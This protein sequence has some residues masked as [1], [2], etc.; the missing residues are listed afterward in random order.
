ML[1]EQLIDGIREVVDALNEAQIEMVL[2]GRPD[3]QNVARFV[4]ANSRWS[5]RSAN[6]DSVA[7]QVLAVFDLEKLDSP[8]FWGTLMR[9]ESGKG[10]ADAAR[11][12]YTS[13]YHLRRFAPPIVSLLDRSNVEQVRGSSEGLLTLYVIEDTG[14]STPTRLIYALQSVESLYSAIAQLEGET[15]H[16]LS[17][18]ACDSGSDKSFDLLGAAKIIQLVKEVFIELWDRIVFHR[19][20]KAEKQ[21]EILSGTLPLYERIA[22]QREAG[23][24]EPEMAEILRRQVASAVEQ[25]FE[26]G[27][28]I[29]EIN[30]RATV[31][32]RRL[33]SPEPKLLTGPPPGHRPDTAVASDDPEPERERSP[34]NTAETEYEEFIAWKNSRE[35]SKRE[36][37]GGEEHGEDAEGGVQD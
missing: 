12:V 7:R 18:V 11:S 27:V 19:E 9:A 1:R 14:S 4:S 22:E 35:R 25:F 36:E 33:M 28:T 13:V 30:D 37:Q 5:V 24:I 3:R 31:D 8:E 16:A 23:S 21:L 15:D 2:R 32:P 10:D 17:V 29:P 34:E 6:F 20:R 26:A